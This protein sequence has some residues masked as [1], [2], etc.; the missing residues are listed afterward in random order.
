MAEDTINKVELKEWS[1]KVAMVT[2]A[3][4]GIGLD[5][6]KTLSV[7]GIR[8]IGCARNISKIEELC[9]ELKGRVSGDISAFKCDVTREN[10]VKSLFEFAA[11]TFG[12]VHILVNNA[13][14]GHNAPLLMGETEHWKEMLDVNVLGL[15]ICTREFYQAQTASGIDNGYIINI[16]SIVGHIVGTSPRNHF[17]SASKFAVTALTEGIRQE[18]RAAKSNIKVSQVSPGLVH[19]EF[20]S[21]LLMDKQ[22]GEEYYKSRLESLSCIECQDVCAGI[23]YLLS[24]PPHVCVND[25]LIRP[26]QQSF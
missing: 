19:T 14:L 1:G 9:V 13:G 20:H 17:Y 15:S 2:G 21:R 5:L 24:T 11:R 16:C 26:L 22:K 8:T 10:E 18:L 12:T 4:S 6:L 3:S 23:L 7:N 25:I